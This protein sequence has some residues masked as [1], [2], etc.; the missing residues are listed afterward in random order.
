M[1]T[2]V[3]GMAPLTERDRPEP[4]QAYSRILVTSTVPDEQNS[5]SPL[6]GYLAQG[7]RRQCPEALVA[8]APFEVTFKRIHD[9]RPEL[10]IAMGGV[11]V[12]GVDL[13]RLRAACDATGA[14]LALWLH[15][16]PFEFD[17]AHR[18]EAIADVIFTNDSWACHHYRFP[19][20]FHLPL[21]GCADTHHQ[22]ILPAAERDIDL[23]FCGVAYPNRVEF[24]RKI[25]HLCRRF[26]CVVLGD[27]WPADLDFAVNRRVPREELADLS[28]RALVTLNITRDHDIANR[29]LD[30]PPS[31]PGPRTFETALAG[32]AQMYLMHG[33]E[34]MDYFEPDSEI[35]LID[36]VMDTEQH[37]QALWSDKDRAVA[38]ATRAQARALK[39]HCYEHRAAAM[40]ARLHAIRW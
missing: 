29:R 16:D 39:E 19:R 3:S 6:R 12:G 24:F 34:I 37:L 38:I 40:L 26:H 15:D 23:L 10:V 36:N 18:A 21:A 28:A 31:T 9:T 14:R 4:H 1:W 5:N 13:R 7:M 2:N 8:E 25:R 17:Y 33:T 27:G 22:P 11:A 35:I 30:L 20:T 32:S